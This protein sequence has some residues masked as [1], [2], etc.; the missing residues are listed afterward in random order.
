MPSSVSAFIGDWGSAEFQLSLPILEVLGAAPKYLG[1]FEG[2]CL[3]GVHFSCV[4]VG[5]SGHP[6]GL[7]SIDRVLVYTV[8]RT[9][10]DPATLVV[11]NHSNSG[12]HERRRRPG[13]SVDDDDDCDFQDLIKRLGD[14]EIRSESSMPT[15]FVSYR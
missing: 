9:S 3:T 7:T 15:S 6:D 12:S 5:R 10:I 8:P 13:T 4:A 1:S 11:R 2:C 14:K